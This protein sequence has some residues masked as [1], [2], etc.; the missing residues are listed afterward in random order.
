MFYD[1]LD[2]KRK[3]ILPALSTFKNE[4]YLA[5]GTGLALQLGHR[6]SIDFDFFT[7]EHFDTAKLYERCR[8][9]FTGRKIVKVQ[10]EKDTL[11]V[12]VDES[13]KISFFRYSYP[14]LA[15]LLDEPYLQIA[16]IADIGCMKLSAI[17][18]RTTEKDYV[19]LYYIFKHIPLVELMDKLN[20]KMPDL[21]HILVLKSL[22]YFK[23]VPDEKIVFK[24][25]CEVAFSKVKEMITNEARQVLEF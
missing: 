23:D 17:V 19:D 7:K 20:D 10:E 4:F 8:E 2:I 15:M 9:V 21:D 12:F 14:L 24:H 1:I 16:S 11:T 13:V 25:N 6:D 5:G 3:E 18:S 22:M